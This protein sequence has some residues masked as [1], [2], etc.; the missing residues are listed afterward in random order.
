MIVTRVAV[1]TTS[2]RATGI[3][4]TLLAHGFEP[5]ILPCIE[6]VPTADDALERA[7]SASAGADWIVVTSPRAVFLTWPSGGMPDVPVAAVGASTAAAVRRAAGAVAMVGEGGAVDLVA[8]LAPMVPGR[9]VV[10]PHGSG[11]DFSTIENLEKAGAR[12]T[13]IPV[14]ETRPV[15]PGLD[16]ADIV[17]FGSPSAII[18]WCRSRSLDGL[19]LTAIGETTGRALVEH[20]YQADV[21]PDRPDYETLVT[22]LDDY[23]RERSLA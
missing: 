21:I 20:G 18:G 7:R 6:V 8:Q 16:P 23:L 9:S 15:A 3:A 12:L 4:E 11:T 22:T 14:Y 2:E 13:A 17:I 19:V 5:V 1:T 10:F